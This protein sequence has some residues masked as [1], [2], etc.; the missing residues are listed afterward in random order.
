[1]RNANG[2]HRLLALSARTGIRK[3]IWNEVVVVDF[4]R[5]K[6]A[7]SERWQELEEMQA[8]KASRR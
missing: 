6:T 7:R 4:A 3:P 2:M 1:M 5:E 8:C